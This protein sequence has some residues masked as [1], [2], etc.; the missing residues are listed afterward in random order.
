MG[1]NDRTDIR[2]FLQTISRN[3]IK[4]VYWPGSDWSNHRR[5]RQDGCIILSMPQYH[6]LRYLLKPHTKH[7][8]P[9]I[10]MCSIEKRSA[11]E[12][13]RRCSSIKLTTTSVCTMH[14]HYRRSQSLAGVGGYYD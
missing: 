9:L 7:T 11:V 5:I 3:H 2:V 12:L 14:V 10:N 6:I 13:F 8:M 4:M 1:N